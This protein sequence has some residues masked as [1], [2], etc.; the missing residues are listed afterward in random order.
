MNYEVGTRV[1]FE[2]AEQKTVA[3]S[4]WEITGIK[5]V[6]NELGEVIKTFVVLN[7]YSEKKDLLVTGQIR[8]T[9]EQLDATATEFVPTPKVDTSAEDAAKAEAKELKR[10][11]KAEAK[12]KKDAD[13]AAKKLE[14]ETKA[15]EAKAIKD[16]EKAKKIAEKEAAKAALEAAKVQV[17]NKNA[18]V[19]VPTE[20]EVVPA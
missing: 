13:K 1:K 19:V 4:P 11:Q 20:T 17:A 8:R 6:K 18:T 12:A 2:N 14:K 9:V 16:A 10:V 7:R 5:P 3:N 15:A